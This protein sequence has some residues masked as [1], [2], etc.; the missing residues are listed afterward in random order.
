MGESTPRQCALPHTFRQCRARRSFQPSGDGVRRFGN[1]HLEH[2]VHDA[3]V[4]VPH[5]RDGPDPRD[6]QLAV[7]ADR[8]VRNVDALDPPIDDID[9]ADRR[10]SRQPVGRQIP[11]LEMARAFGHPRA[12]RARTRRPRTA[13]PWPRCSPPRAGP[14]SPCS[15]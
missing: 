4:I 7:R 15:R 2:L 14:M 13:A 11:A 1:A 9:T 6:I 8:L 12:R 3:I 5:P 10:V